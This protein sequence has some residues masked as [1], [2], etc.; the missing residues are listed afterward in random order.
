MEMQLDKFLVEIIFPGMGRNYDFWIPKEM[1]IQKVI[2]EVVTEIVQFEKSTVSSQNMEG[3]MLCSK[4][5]GEILCTQTTVLEA[6]VRS[7]DTLVLL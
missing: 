1:Q 3:M 7:G 5:T 2:E 6:G 4:R